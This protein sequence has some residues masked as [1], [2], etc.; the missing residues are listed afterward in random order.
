MRGGGTWG[1]SKPSCQFCC[2]SKTNPRLLKK[3]SQRKKFNTQGRK[4][5]KEK[6][7][8]YTFYYSVISQGCWNK[9]LQIWGLTGG[10]VVNN[11][12]AN[13]GDTGSIPGWED[14][15]ENETTTHS[16]IL[17][18]EIPWTEE[19]GG[20]QSV[21]LRQVGHDL[22]TEQTHHTDLVFLEARSLKWVSPGQNQGVGRAML[23]P[24]AFGENPMPFPA[25][26]GC[27][28]SLACGS[29]LVFKRLHSHLCFGLT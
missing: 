5:K 16:S 6:N 25:A 15:L 10:A 14:P 4:K 12:P 13:E 3:S 9:W 26:R 18:W 27:L 24:E 7:G 20:L 8:C 2:K 19:P 21:G 17:A 1:I 22:V 29:F 11:L 23:P 28:L